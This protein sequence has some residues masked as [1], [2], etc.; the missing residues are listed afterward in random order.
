MAIKDSAKWLTRRPAL[1]MALVGTLGLVVG[2]GVGF[3]VEQSRTRADVNHLKARIANIKSPKT[4][5]VVKRSGLL[6]E[7]VGTVTAAGSNGFAVT[8][9]KHRTYQVGTTSATK[10]EQA[11]SGSKSDI[12]VGRRVLVSVS[13]SDVIVLP[14]GSLLGRPVTRVKGA[15]FSVEKSGGKAAKV[16]SFAKVKVIDSITDASS[17]ALKKGSD[18]LAFGQASNDGS[19]GATTVIL[20]PTGSA[21]TNQ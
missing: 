10:F 14:P 17:A 21:F 20:L 2:L 18:V 5:P 19:F 6:N 4:K 8:T 12:A 15:S 7:R 1:G 3:K 9:K 16:V 13:G 11:G